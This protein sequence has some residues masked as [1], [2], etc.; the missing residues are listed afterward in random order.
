MTIMCD[1]D[2]FNNNINLDKNSNVN[3]IQ[4]I[5]RDYYL[6]PGTIVTAMG[7]CDTIEKFSIS[8]IIDYVNRAFI[9][10]YSKRD[11]VLL[12]INSPYGHALKPTDMDSRM[13]EVSTYRHN[14]ASISQLIYYRNNKMSADD[15]IEVIADRGKEEQSRLGLLVI[16][17]DAMDLNSGLTSLKEYAKDNGINIIV[18]ATPKVSNDDFY[19]TGSI[20]TKLVSDVNGMPKDTIHL[21]IELDLDGGS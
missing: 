19:L 13:C 15:V 7:E 10:S 20:D 2:T 6:Y 5:L 14:S 11:A 8:A 9:S 3:Q 18:M 21:S 17:H 12:S 16:D 4:R 1:T